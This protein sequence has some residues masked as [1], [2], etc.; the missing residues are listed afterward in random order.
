LLVCLCARGRGKR[1]R[2]A[3]VGWLT[4]MYM[5]IYIYIHA[6]VREQIHVQNDDAEFEYIFTKLCVCTYTRTF[7]GKSHTKS[8]TFCQQSPILCQKSPDFGPKYAYVLTF[9]Y[10]EEYI[11]VH[12]THNKRT[13]EYTYIY[14][15]IS[16][17]LYVATDR[18]WLPIFRIY[19]VRGL[20]NKEMKFQI[21]GAVLVQIAPLWMSQPRNQNQSISSWLSNSPLWTPHSDTCMH[22]YICTCVHVHKYTRIHLYTY[23]MHVCIHAHVCM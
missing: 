14:E 7:G 10:T 5:C 9:M 8:P 1:W 21:K 20:W 23:I 18:L 17:V 15:N 22:T 11:P 16:N 13:H 12:V 3:R 2:L 6:D 19:L 4:N